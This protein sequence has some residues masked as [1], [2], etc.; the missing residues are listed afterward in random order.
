MLR[1]VLVVLRSHRGL[2]FT[3]LFRTFQQVNLPASGT[4]LAS[5]SGGDRGRWESSPGA[6]H[7]R[8]WLCRLLRIHCT[9]RDGPRMPRHPPRRG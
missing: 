6:V 3:S 1:V 9:G 5:D 7:D 8:P 2:R 4:H